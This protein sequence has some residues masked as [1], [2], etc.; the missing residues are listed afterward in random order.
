MPF[1]A[2]FIAFIL[3]YIVFLKDY[4]SVLVF[5]YMNLFLFVVF[6]FILLISYLVTKRTWLTKKYI[7][8]PETILIVDSVAGA[9][10]RSHNLKG[11]TNIKL[12]QSPF[13]KQFNYGT[14][15]VYFMGGSFITLTHI[16]EP[17]VHLNNINAL[18][19]KGYIEAS[20]E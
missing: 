1:F 2:G 12:H 3:A 19:N 20:S 18:I 7:I 6:S 11:V 13:A 4:I 16:S 15:T 10:Y 9:Q 5:V 14:I 17:V 8:S